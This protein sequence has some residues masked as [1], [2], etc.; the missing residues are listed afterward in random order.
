M[1]T[2]LRQ[3]IGGAALFTIAI[4]GGFF[5]GR[6]FPEPIDITPPPIIPDP[7]TPIDSGNTYRPGR[8]VTGIDVQTIFGNYSTQVKTPAKTNI[9]HLEDYNIVSLEQMRAWTESVQS[10]SYIVINPGINSGSIGR[11]GVHT[12]LYFLDA[13]F[14]PILENSDIKMYN[15]LM[16]CPP[17]CPSNNIRY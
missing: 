1:N 11:N 12:Y 10:P 16:R 9:S 5:I 7:Y 15:D 2:N 17:F 13:N 3:I 6:M 14:R 4:V 8:E